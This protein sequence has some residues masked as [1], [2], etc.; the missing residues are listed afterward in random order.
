MYDFELDSDQQLAVESRSRAVVCVAGAGSGKTEVVARRIERILEESPD[1]EFRVLALSYT[2]KA[3][4]ELD[5]RFR[6]RLGDLRRRVDADTIHGFAL[7]LL[8]RHGTRIGLPLEPEV[9]AR[10]EDRIELL[11]SWLIE[12][13]YGLS[14]LET[15]EVIPRL[16]LARAKGT[17]APYL[18]EWRAA[19]DSRGA[20]DFPAMLERACEL[21][22][23][24][25]IQRQLHR[26]YEHVIVDEAQNLTPAQ[27]EFLRRLIGEPGAG[28]I[29]AMVVG[30]ERQS[31]VTFAGA[32]PS[33]IARFEMEYE[34]QRIELLH[35]Y[36]S[37]GRII[38]VGHA[39]AKALGTP[40]SSATGVY[41]AQGVVE[42]AEATDEES[43]AALVAGWVSGLLEHGLPKE[44]LAPGEST[45]VRTEEIAV[46]ARGGSALRRT[47]EAL[48]ASGIESAVASTEDDW[49]RSKDAQLLVELIAFRAA[50]GHRSTHRRIEELLGLEES[51]WSRPE[52]VLVDAKR[53]DLDRLF[54]ADDPLELIDIARTLDMEDPDWLADLHQLEDTVGSFV[55]RVDVADR[56]FG[57]FRQHITRCQRGDS[58]APGIRL[59][60]VHKAQGREFKAVAIVACNDGQFPD[61]RATADEER[62]SELRTFYVAVSRPTRVLLLTRAQSRDTRYGPRPTERSPFLDLVPTSALLSDR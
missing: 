48:S 29:N 11:K 26:L 46:L 9:L 4:D 40:V 21:L 34:A 31:I 49:V 42:L 47:R 5:S 14:D 3:A 1:E 10:D 6:E 35:N 30:D 59:L 33:L 16:D 38:E 51:D 58:L 22:E 24:P 7:A 53:P 52:A 19:L 44:S 13:G 39:I 61:F 27:F 62:T 17:A 37:A 20:L 32:D 54:H 23:T 18:D 28:Q 15:T 36:R 43:E 60:T 45:R 8:R 57:N 2:V 55:D 50:P 12:Q 25:F 56:S 41:A